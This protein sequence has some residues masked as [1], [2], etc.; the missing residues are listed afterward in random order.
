MHKNI[1]RR[2]KRDDMY[3]NKN[4]IEKVCGQIFISM[5]FYEVSGLRK[6]IGSVIK[7]TIKLSKKSL[8]KQTLRMNFVV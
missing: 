3:G 4:S 6:I 5:I 8:T 2:P 7:P 1:K